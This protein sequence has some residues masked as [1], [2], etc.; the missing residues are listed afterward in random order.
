MIELHRKYPRKIVKLDS[1]VIAVIY[2]PNDSRNKGRGELIVSEEIDGR[3]GMFFQR[4]RMCV[5]SY[6]GKEIPIHT[7]TFSLK[8]HKN[9]PP[10][11]IIELRTSK[12]ATVVCILYFVILFTVFGVYSFV[13]GLT[14]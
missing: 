10:T 4:P 11:E 5:L 14:V 3:T 13:K 1:K 6:D 12:I 2:G 7:P 8:P 9:H